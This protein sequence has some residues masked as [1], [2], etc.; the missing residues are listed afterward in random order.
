MSTA[1]VLENG[2]IAVKIDFYLSVLDIDKLFATIYNTLESP[3]SS[4]T[5]E[6]WVFFLNPKIIY[7]L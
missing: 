4:F 2:K 7:I 5:S 3:V 1:L 6:K